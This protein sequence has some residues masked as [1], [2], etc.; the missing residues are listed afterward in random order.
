MPLWR[1]LYLGGPVTVVPNRLAV[2]VLYN[3]VPWIGI[4]AAGYLY[5]QRQ[6]DNITNDK[7]TDLSAITDLKL[8]QID[9][10]RRERLADARMISENRPLVLRV[11]QW[12][13]DAR[14]GGLEDELAGWT[15]LR[16]KNG[17]YAMGFLFDAAGWLRCTR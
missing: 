11:Q 4:M 17:Q 15:A 2:T 16:E 14:T 7:R 13:N 8:N 9:G 12:L 1:V 5:Y 3:V 10:W 6:R